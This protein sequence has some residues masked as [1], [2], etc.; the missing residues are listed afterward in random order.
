MDNTQLSE[1]AFDSLLRVAVIER[2]YEELDQY[3]SREELNLIDDS[4]VDRRLRKWIRKIERKAALKNMYRSVSKVAAILLILCGLGFIG[5][6]QVEEVR[7]SCV[8]FFKTVYEK[9]IRYD[10]SSTSPENNFIVEYVPAGYQ[11]VDNLWDENLNRKIYAD[12][13][14][15]RLTISFVLMQK[16]SGHVD[17]EDCTIDSFLINGNECQSHIY[18]NEK[19]NKLI[20]STELGAFTIK[21]KLP[22]EEL[23]KIAKNLK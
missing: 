8:D 9:F 7:A 12:E 10:I 17:N 20:M 6:L 14:G 21:G 18:D 23:E 4:S 16:V 19:D 13:D 22:K 15:T 1:E 5:L 2:C 3:P 11:L